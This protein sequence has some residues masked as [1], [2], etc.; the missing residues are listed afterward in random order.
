MG[1]VDRTARLTIDGHVA[2]LTM[3]RPE[4]LISLNPQMLDEILE[5]LEVVRRSQDVSALVLTGEGRAFC[6][7]VD[8]DT[9]FFLNHVDHDS[10]YAV[11][12]C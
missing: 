6:A 7:G 8:I 9:P 1:G 2:V 11:R 12:V 5:A 10:V 4:Q 3:A